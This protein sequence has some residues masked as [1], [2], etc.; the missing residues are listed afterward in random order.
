MGGTLINLVNQGRNVQ[1]AYMTSGNIAVFDH[2]ALRHIDYLQEFNQIFGL[3]TDGSRNLQRKMRQAMA[4]KQPGDPD[5]AEVLNVKLLI[6][7][8][9]ATAAAQVAGVVDND[10]HFL[11]LPFYRTGEV[12]KRPVGDEDVEIIARLLRQ[13]KPAQIFV[14]GDLSDPH[15]THRVCAEAIFQALERVRSD[16]VEPAVWL[17]RGAW[18][19]F[20]PHEIEMAVPLSPEVALQKKMAI[21]KHESQKDRALFPGNDEREFWV[22][23]E[24]RTKKTARIYNE[25]GLPEFFAL[26]GFVRSTGGL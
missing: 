4:S 9:E 1:I 15:G 3:N 20:E 24:E 21:F 7:K 5:I 14:A 26:E 6:R 2:D 11:D 25:L 23:A 8:T 10:L 19:E 22:R 12:T 13:Q 16:G 18:Q 17:Y